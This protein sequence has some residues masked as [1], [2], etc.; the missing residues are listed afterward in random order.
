MCSHD[1][2]ARGRVRVYT[3]SPVSVAAASLVAQVVKNL[4]AMQETR[5]HPWVG[6]VPW[7][8]DSYPLWESCLENPM[9]RGAWRK[10]T[11]LGSVFAQAA[12]CR[13]HA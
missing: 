5:F 7:R 12:N 9:D 10:Q 13:L 11:E 2:A 8:R 3:R 6:K 4:P 1:H